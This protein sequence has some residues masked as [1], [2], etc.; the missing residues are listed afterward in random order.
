MVKRE[1]SENRMVQAEN[2]LHFGQLNPIEQDSNFLGLARASESTFQITPQRISSQPESFFYR[3]VFS[4]SFYNGE[5]QP[6]QITDPLRGTEESG[7]RSGK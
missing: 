6:H 7:K 1:Q 5:D 3:V 2:I 4:V